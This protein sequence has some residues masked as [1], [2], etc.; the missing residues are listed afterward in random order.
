M[1][2]MYSWTGDLILVFITE[3]RVL[4]WRERCGLMH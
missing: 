1:L 2:P 4:E 3:F